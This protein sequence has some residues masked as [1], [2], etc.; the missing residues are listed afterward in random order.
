[1]SSSELFSY[2]SSGFHLLAMS[3]FSLAS[4]DIVRGKKTIMSF[5]PLYQ[6]RKFQFCER[7]DILKDG[8]SIYFCRFFILMGSVRISSNKCEALGLTAE[9]EMRNKPCFCWASLG[10]YRSCIYGWKQKYPFP[11]EPILFKHLN[12]K[13]SSMLFLH[14]RN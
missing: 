14:S 4:P 13:L 1:M 11:T 10:R 9:Q 6:P 5:K 12:R 3:R 7:S 8:W 2:P